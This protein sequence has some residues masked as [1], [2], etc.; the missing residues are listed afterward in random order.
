[1]TTENERLVESI[2]NDAPRLNAD[3]RLRFGCHPG[4]ACFNACCGDVN[5]VLTPYDVL[6][7]R[8]RLGLGAEE[9]IARHTIVPF[10]KEQ[11]LPIPLLKMGT[12]EKKSCP[13]VGPAGCTVYEDRPWPCRMYPVG[14][15]ASGTRSRPGEQ[16][17]F[18]LE[19]PH[20]RGHEGGREWTVA[21]W[22]GDQKVA[23]FDEFGELFKEVTLHPRLLD[24]PPLPP[25]QLELYFMATYELDRFRRFIF[26]SRFLQTFEVA[27][28]YAEKLRTD[29]EELLRFGFLW[30]RF[31]LFG[32]KTVKIRPEAL[33][34]KQR[35]IASR[36]V[37]GA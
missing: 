36:A 9:F 35:E 15:A 10:S 20:C 19:E 14:V 8:R 16:F 32:E 26:D 33:A 18:L 24:G 5:I 29:D 11:K 27:T 4:V 31:S 7:L 23:E 34:A 13:F 37:T 22:L 25:K 2:I 17:Y 28:D 3:S 21:E 12:D 6:R 30:L 1:M